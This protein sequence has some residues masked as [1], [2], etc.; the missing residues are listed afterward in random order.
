M[1]ALYLETLKIRL[2][3]LWAPDGAAGVPAHCWGVGLDGL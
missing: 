2:E 3:G 1:N